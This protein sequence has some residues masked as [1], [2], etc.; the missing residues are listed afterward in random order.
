MT[1]RSLQH[2]LELSIFTLAQY[3]P[4]QCVAERRKRRTI[5]GTEGRPP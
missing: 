5:V 2:L 3:W 4:C 1:K